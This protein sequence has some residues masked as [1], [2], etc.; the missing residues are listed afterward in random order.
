MAQI[1]KR[2][3]EACQVQLVFLVVWL[4]LGIFNIPTNH[5]TNCHTQF[6]WDEWK[7]RTLTQN[8][9]ACGL[10]VFRPVFWKLEDTTFRKLHIFP[11]SGDGRETFTLLGP[12]ERVKVNQVAASLLTWRWEHVYR[13]ADNSRP[14]SF[15][16]CVW[17]RVYATSLSH[18]KR[19]RV[20]E[21]QT[22]LRRR[23]Q[24]TN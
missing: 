1:W 16:V 19:E 22:A 4:P 21:K 2:T 12:S 23:T 9:W 15:T 5:S 17:E 8:R 3:L 10:C 18:L 20:I 7:L 11:S 13:R 14:V 24:C 6:L